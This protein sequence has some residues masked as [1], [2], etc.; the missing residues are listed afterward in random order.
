[1]ENSTR[2]YIDLINEIAPVVQE[3]IAENKNNSTTIDPLSTDNFN[4][5]LDN[6]NSTL[7]FNKKEFNGSINST[8]DNTPND[9]S[10]QL[11]NSS[12]KIAEF[13]YSP[14]NMKFIQNKIK[15]AAYNNLNVLISDQDELEILKVMQFVYNNYLISNY[16]AKVNSPEFIEI[17]SGL[18][19]ELLNLILPD[20]IE[21]IKSYQ[22][23]SQFV[24]EGINPI[25]LP[26]NTSIKG[27]NTLEIKF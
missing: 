27:S 9:I 2:R 6:Y 15:E 14:R 17:I 22:G 3:Q 18:N 4:K 11:Q 21:N 5:F 13:F 24:S 20:I 26:V 7:L 16:N 19:E 8:I 10:R 25:D 1:M 12:N 23:Y